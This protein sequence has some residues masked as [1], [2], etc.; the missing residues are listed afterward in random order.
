MLT[1]ESIGV[2]V[3]SII[4]DLFAHDTDVALGRDG[5]PAVRGK[6]G[7]KYLGKYTWLL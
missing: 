2:L 5:F 1:E 3:G 7:G 6:E 4:V